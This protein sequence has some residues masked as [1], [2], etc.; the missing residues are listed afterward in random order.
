MI[1]SKFSI[2]KQHHHK[3]VNTLARLNTL[4]V[5]NYD[6]GMPRICLAKMPQLEIDLHGCATK[7]EDFQMEKKVWITS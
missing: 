2:C 6:L 7:Q 5:L 3:V 1:L 4:F